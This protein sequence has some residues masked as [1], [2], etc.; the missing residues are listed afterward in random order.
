MFDSREINRALLGAL[1][2]LLMSAGI[3]YMQGTSMDA[4][5]LKSA[6]GRDLALP[7]GMRVMTRSHALRNPPAT[8]LEVPL[9]AVAAPSNE[10]PL[11]PSCR[12]AK[13]IQAQ[14][15]GAKSMDETLTQKLAVIVQHYCPSIDT[16]E[17]ASTGT[18]TEIDNWCERFSPLSARFAACNAAQQAGIPYEIGK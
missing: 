16:Y 12:V 7:G 3:L 13:D 10:A 9:P 6:A 4:N 8:S 14:L 2:G 5:I 17:E 18:G 11:A 15:L 1:V